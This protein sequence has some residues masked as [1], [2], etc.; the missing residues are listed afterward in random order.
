MFANGKRA[1]RGAD[2]DEKNVALRQQFDS[3]REPCL[4]QTG[5]VSPARLFVVFVSLEKLGRFGFMWERLCRLKE[6]C[7]EVLRFEVLTLFKTCR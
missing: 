6:T 2:N 3:S 1:R 7:P 4:I 5:M